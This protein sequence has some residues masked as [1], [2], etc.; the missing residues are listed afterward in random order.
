MLDPHLKEPPRVNLIA[1]GEVIRLLVT[2]PLIRPKRREEKLELILSR[3]SSTELL[4]SFVNRGC[5]IIRTDQPVKLISLFTIGLSMRSAKVLA[6]ALENHLKQEEDNGK[7][8]TEP[9]STPN[10]KCKSVKGGSSR[11]R[12]TKS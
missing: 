7:T 3:I 1:E 11:T 10:R 6:T 4:C 5:C 8:T 12:Q 2:D 9:T